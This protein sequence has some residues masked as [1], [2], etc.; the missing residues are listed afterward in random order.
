MGFTF[1]FFHVPGKTPDSMLLLII[2][3][4][5]GVNAFGAIFNNHGPML[6]RPVAFVTSIFAR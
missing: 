5:E 2:Y 1:A 3:V 4:M 6:S